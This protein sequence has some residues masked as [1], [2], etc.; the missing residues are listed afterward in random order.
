[1]NELIQWCEARLGVIEKDGDW[2]EMRSNGENFLNTQIE[3]KKY[4][5]EWRWNSNDISKLIWKSEYLG[6]ELFILCRQR[7]HSFLRRDMIFREMPFQAIPR[8]HFIKKNLSS[9]YSNHNTN[10]SSDS[11]LLYTRTNEM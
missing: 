4:F 9:L 8:N 1:M 7:R 11:E 6:N 5:P 10:G 3:T 2:T